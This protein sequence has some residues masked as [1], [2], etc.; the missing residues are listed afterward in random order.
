MLPL[1][2]GGP[3]PSFK[4]P[5]LLKPEPPNL[6]PRAEPHDQVPNVSGALPLPFVNGGVA[7][8]E[9]FECPCEAPCNE[10]EEKLSRILWSSF[11]A[12]GPRFGDD[13]YCDEV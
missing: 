2:V 13:G 10:Y 3:D 8:R 9:P 7:G 6:S 5:E 1:R 4:R 11:M 12:V